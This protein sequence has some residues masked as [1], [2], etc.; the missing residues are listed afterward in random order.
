M[1]DEGLAKFK[2]DKG[3][4][5]ICIGVKEFECVGASPPHDHPHIYLEMGVADMILCPYYGTLFRYPPL[6][7]RWA[8]PSASTLTDLLG[9]AESALC[10]MRASMQMT[11][12]SGRR[13]GRKKAAACG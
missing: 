5:E 9:R 12:A 2:N 7:A 6:R 3:V 11:G 4:P 10:A 13:R 8:S 1:S